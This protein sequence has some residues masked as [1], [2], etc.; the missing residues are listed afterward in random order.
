MRR[1][2]SPREGIITEEFD[3]VND[4]R[5]GA[6]GHPNSELRGVPAD[7]AGAIADGGGTGVSTSKGR[8]LIVEDEYFVAL[9]V[10]DALMDAGI[11]VVGVAATADEAIA[12]TTAA[13]P[14]LV[15]MDIRLAGPRDGIE[16]ATE[17]LQQL[18]IRSLFATGNSDPTTQARGTRL[19][20]PLGW[21]SKPY[22]QAELVTAVTAA[23]RQTRG[24]GGGP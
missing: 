8:V 4:S 19:A 13:K 18:G 21:L 11:T 7:L 15:L 24:S 2:V 20:S 22:T 16:A 14:D 17:I 12:L 10:E 1:S 9:F 6:T 5:P 23:L 3:A